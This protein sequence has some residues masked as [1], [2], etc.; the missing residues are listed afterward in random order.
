MPTVYDLSAPK[1]A[2]EVLIND[3]LLSKAEA[4]E[5]NLSAVLEKALAETVARPHEGERCVEES[6]NSVEGVSVNGIDP[7]L[8][9][10]AMGVFGDDQRAVQ[11][12]CTPMRALGDKRP[13]DAG[14]EE[15]IDLLGR[16][17]HGFSA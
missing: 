11:W 8:M 16:I 6:R 4:L 14:I 5:V 12:L 7:G 9:V 2:V 17:E 13:V 10:A 1:R 15:V 3:D